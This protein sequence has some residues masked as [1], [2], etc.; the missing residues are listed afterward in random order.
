[1]SEQAKAAAQAIKEAMK[2]A[3][4]TAVEQAATYLSGLAD[5]MRLAA[6]NQQKEEK[7]ND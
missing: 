6:K 5:G 1:M 2:A 3:P 4:P 7:S